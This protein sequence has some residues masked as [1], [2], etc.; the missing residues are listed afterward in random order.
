MIDAIKQIDGYESMTPEQIADA[1]R[2]IT[3]TAEPREC[4]S[5]ETTHAIIAA[6][7]D[8]S[9][10]E[11]IALALEST[12]TGRMIGSKLASTG[13]AW[14]HP[15]TRPVL[16]GMVA[17][18]AISQSVMDALVALS[19][20]TTHPYADVTPEQV[21]D[22]LSE[23]AKRVAIEAFLP[24]WESRKAVIEHGIFEGTITSLDDII[25]VFR[26]A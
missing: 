17:A 10:V 2:S 21:A 7:G 25:A 3:V 18:K 16:Q 20:P 22:V 15:L 1:L 23:E 24:V 26:G 8:P 19:A 14:A 13:V 4:G 9:S 5:A 11:L 12:A 6:T